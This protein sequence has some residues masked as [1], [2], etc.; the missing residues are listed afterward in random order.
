MNTPDERLQYELARVRVWLASLDEF[1]Q[2]FRPNRAAVFGLVVLAAMALVALFAPVL[3]PFPPHRVSSD[4]FEPPNAKHWMGTDDVGRDTFSGNV[5]SARTSLIV[6]II[7]SLTS[8]SIGTVIGALS[9]FLGGRV[10]DWLMRFTEFVLITPPF[11]LILVAVAIV[12]PSLLNIILVIGLFSWPRIARVVRALF[13]SLK[14]EDYVLAARAIGAPDARIIY[15]HILPNTL[16]SII[17]LGSLLVGQAIL[18]EAGLSFLGL[19]DPVAFSW[20]K[21]LNNAQRFLGQS[22]WMAFFPGAAIFLTVLSV[23][24]IGDG[25]NDA[26]NPRLRHRK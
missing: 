9:G 5:M 13:L 15:G 12:G 1:W 25:I 26:L 21:M 22:L 16:P 7:A 14:E 11:F 10:D 23:N 3:A 19:G 24:L 8:I 20:G 18:N 4:T 2:R 17:V 6:G